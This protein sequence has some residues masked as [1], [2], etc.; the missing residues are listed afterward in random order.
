MRNKQFFI[1][2]LA[3][4]LSGISCSKKTPELTLSEADIAANNRGVALMGYFDYSGARNT[5]D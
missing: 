3:L 4:F 5:F 1:L 2:T